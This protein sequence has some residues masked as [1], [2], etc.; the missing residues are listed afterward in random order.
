MC[1]LQLMVMRTKISGINGDV[2]V[3]SHGTAVRFK[4]VQPLYKF[5]TKITLMFTSHIVGTN[6][7]S[8]VKQQ[9]FQFWGIS[10]KNLREIGYLHRKLYAWATLRVF[11]LCVPADIIFKFILIWKYIS[12]NGNI[13]RTEFFRETF[14]LLKMFQL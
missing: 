3:N 11:N 7:V 9:L 2:G 1:G 6:K 13:Y 4:H 14:F 5:Q 8:S 12:R 10:L